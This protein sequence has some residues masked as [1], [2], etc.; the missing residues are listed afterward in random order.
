M[1]VD[2]LGRDIASLEVLP[3]S[4]PNGKSNLMFVI[5]IRH[6]RLS[7][8]DHHESALLFQRLSV[9]IRCYNAVAVWGTRGWNVAIPAFVLVFS[10]P[11]VCTTLDKEMRT[12]FIAAS[13][14]VQNHTL[15]FTR[16]TQM[17]VDQHQMA[18]SS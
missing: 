14:M 10:P 12:I 3:N 6:S 17:N 18:A 4:R 9:L 15:E 5:I 13:F 16:V 2:D 8:D 1:E 7:T 11:G